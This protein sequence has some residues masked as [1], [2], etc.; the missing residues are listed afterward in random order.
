MNIRIKIIPMVAAFVASIV[1]VGFAGAPDALAYCPS[2]N[3]WS[4]GHGH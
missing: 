3:T 2:S 4:N 1:F